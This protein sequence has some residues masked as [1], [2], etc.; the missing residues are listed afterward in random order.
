MHI[1]SVKYNWGFQLSVLWIGIAL[2]PL[3]IRIWILDW[4][5]NNA[6]PHADLTPSLHKLE[7][8]AIYSQQ[9]Q[10]IMFFFSKMCHGF[11]YFGQNI[12][13]FMK[14]LKK[15]M[16]LELIPIQIGLWCRSGSGK[17]MRSRPDP[18]PDLQH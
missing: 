17:M 11:K 14:K 16:C 2:M 7:N 12:E 1:C 8:R 3:R 18:N 9:Y 5:Q 4:H 15:Y 10:F 6:Y 13:I